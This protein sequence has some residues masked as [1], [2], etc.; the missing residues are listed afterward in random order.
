MTTSPDW[1]EMAEQCLTSP[2]NNVAL[3]R[4]ICKALMARD[5]YPL[6]GTLIANAI[7]S[8]LLGSAIELVQHLFP[9][10]GMQVGIPLTARSPSGWYASVFREKR[11]G[12]HGH[13]SGRFRQDSSEPDPVV[14]GARWRYA[15]SPALA[16]V[17]A[18]LRVL[19]CHEA[20]S[21]AVETPPDSPPGGQP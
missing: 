16:L 9:G 10:W 6:V 4:F 3:S 20:G 1:N 17:A 19:A 2:P 5:D 11:E 12:E 13:L 8:D 21:P 7:A 14:K 15:S 18:L